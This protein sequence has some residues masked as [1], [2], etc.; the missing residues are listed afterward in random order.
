MFLALLAGGDFASFA[1][2]WIE[3]ACY[4]EESAKANATAEASISTA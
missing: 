3:D 2:A 1:T 4:L